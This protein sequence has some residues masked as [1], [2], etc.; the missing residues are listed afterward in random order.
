MQYTLS[1]LKATVVDAAIA[2]DKQWTAK[3]CDR[4]SFDKAAKASFPNSNIDFRGYHSWLIVAQNMGVDTTPW[5]QPKTTGMKLSELKIQVYAH[6]Q[7][8]DTK[9]LKIKLDEWGILFGK[10]TFKASWQQLWDE[11]Q[12][13][14]AQMAA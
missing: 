12:N 11:V 5:Q 9:A 10:L 6:Y 4:K 14:P 7:V 8:S 3:V 2:S 13:T 1:T